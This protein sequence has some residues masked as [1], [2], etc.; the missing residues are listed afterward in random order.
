MLRNLSEAKNIALKG[1]LMLQEKNTRFIGNRT[2]YGI[3]GPSSS[4]RVV[5]ETNK[6]IVEES[7]ENN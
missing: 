5:V 2:E 7:G 6:S 3:E 1:E 4:S